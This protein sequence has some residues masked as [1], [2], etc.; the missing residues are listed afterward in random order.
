MKRSIG[1]L[2]AKAGAELI[3]DFIGNVVLLE[4]VLSSGWKLEFNLLF[5]IR[6]HM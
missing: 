4:D 3:A 2:E 5:K 1:L 6:M